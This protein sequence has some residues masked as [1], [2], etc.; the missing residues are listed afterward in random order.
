MKRRQPGIDDEAADAMDF[1]TSL[2]DDSF[3]TFSSPFPHPEDANS[4]QAFGSS[5]D[6][7]L[8]STML[9]EECNDPPEG[10]LVL[11]GM[12]LEQ[13]SSKPQTVDDLARLVEQELAHRAFQIEPVVVFYH[14]V[15]NGIITSTKSTDNC[16]ISFKFSGM[17]NMSRFSIYTALD[18]QKGVR[19]KLSR[20][21][22]VAL[23]NALD[24]LQSGAGDGCSAEQLLDSLQSHCTL[25]SGL[26][27]N[28]IVDYLLRMAKISFDSETGNIHGHFFNSEA[29][30][31]VLY[32]ATI[33]DKQKEAKT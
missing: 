18:M 26:D 25:T 7:A 9:V 23:K 19:K 16:P 32:Q 28:E 14:L 6:H 31:N 11:S 30:R 33:Q 10:L 2:S 29:N 15:L 22:K 4:P 12:L 8:Y 1:T 24:W 17:G 27:T 13:L 20:D 3:L 21:F 5:R